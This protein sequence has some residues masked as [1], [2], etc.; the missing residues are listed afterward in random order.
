MALSKFNFCLKRVQIASIVFQRYSYASFKIHET[1]CISLDNEEITSSFRIALDINRSAI[2][3][4]LSCGIIE[5]CLI[6]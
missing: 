1:T 4:P 3:S 6:I 5:K 2:I